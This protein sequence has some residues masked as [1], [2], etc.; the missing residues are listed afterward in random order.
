MVKFSG[1]SKA[2]VFVLTSGNL[3]PG[4]GRWGQRFALCLSNKTTFNVLRDSKIGCN[5]S[6][7][8]FVN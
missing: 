2:S 1:G 7:H 6:F 4:F 8:P 3:F 5:F